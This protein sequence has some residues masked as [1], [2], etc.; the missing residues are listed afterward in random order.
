MHATAGRQ[1]GRQARAQVGP[2][3]TGRSRH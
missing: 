3:G 1:A 2:L